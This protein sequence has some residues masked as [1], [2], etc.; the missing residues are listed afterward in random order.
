MLLLLRSLVNQSFGFFAFG[1]ANRS[2]SMATESPSLQ[3][4]V[5][6]NSLDNGNGDSLYFRGFDSL[7]AQEM[8]WCQTMK[9]AL[10]AKV[11]L[12]F[13]DA[14]RVRLDCGDFFED[15]SSG[16][17]HDHNFM[18]AIAQEMTKMMEGEQVQDDNA[19]ALSTYANFVGTSIACSYSSICC[20]SEYD[21]SR[22]WVIDTGASDHMWL[23][24]KTYL[25]L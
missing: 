7:G 19:G 2:N 10:G 18:M 9:V 11:N 3:E 25:F 17:L 6:R 13:I 14:S 8:R 5:L 22:F 23:A 24:M 20:L 15:T 1:S 4:F 21:S 12:G 16:A